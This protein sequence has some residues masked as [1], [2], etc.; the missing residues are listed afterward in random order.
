M[1]KKISILFI[2]ICNIVNVFAQQPNYSSK[3]KVVSTP[4][5]EGLKKLP[6][7]S[8]NSYMYKFA[9]SIQ[10]VEK[11]Y[12]INYQEYYKNE[13]VHIDIVARGIQKENRSTK[14]EVIL[15]PLQK[16]LYKVFINLP[17]SMNFLSAKAKEGNVLKYHLF[18][19]PQT[20]KK[21]FMLLIYEDAEDSDKNEKLVKR[22]YN[23]DFTTFFEKKNIQKTPSLEH[24]YVVYYTLEDTANPIE[25]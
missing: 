12:S 25:K 7:P 20:E 10:P 11:R 18:S 21:A 5:G 1:E 4:R 3:V 16:D 8:K 2:L 14:F 22:L 13:P 9:T 19:S 23:K 6:R 17:S 15:D 24:F